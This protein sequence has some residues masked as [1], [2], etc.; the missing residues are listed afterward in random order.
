MAVALSVVVPVK[1]EVENVGPLVREIASALAGE[2][3]EIIF[4]DDGSRDGTGDALRALKAEIRPCASSSTRAILAR[5]GASAPAF[6]RRGP[7]LS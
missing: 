6:A 3:A 4:I 1:D 2:N 7:I 5:A